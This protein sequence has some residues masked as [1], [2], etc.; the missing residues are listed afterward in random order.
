MPRDADRQ[1]LIEQMT[2]QFQKKLE[3]EIP[4]DNAT[5]DQI[6]DA[7]DR[8]GK[9]ILGALQ[10]RLAN[11]RAQQPRQNQVDCTCG[12]R[13]R[14]RAL[15]SK[16]LVTRHGLL[17]WKRPTY[18]CP[19]CKQGVAPLDATLGLDRGETTTCVREWVALLAPQVGFVPTATVL[20][21]VR[22]LTLSAATIERI[23]VRCGSS[24]RTAQLREAQAHHQDTLPDQRTPCPRRLYIGAD[25]VMTPLRDAWKKDK[26]L[27]DLHCR[28]GECKTG[29]VY[30]THQDKQ[31]KDGRVHTRSYIAT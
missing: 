17:V 11:Q 9:E 4:D 12:G 31:G 27:G 10:E 18:Y 16:T 15:A 13:A 21:R 29:V 5:L 20:E 26:S 6:E 8:I 3:Q 25:G 7:V 2:K 1:A 19:T 23:A 22:G 24:L 30:E 14:F 28:Y